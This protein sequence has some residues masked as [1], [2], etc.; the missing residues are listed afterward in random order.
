MPERTD[1]AGKAVGEA[2]RELSFTGTI[3]ASLIG[4]ALL[5]ALIVLLSFWAFRQ[6][7]ESVAARLH[8]YTLISKADALLSDI[9]NAE[10]GQ[11]GYS[12][13]G[14]EAFLKPYLAVRETIVRDLEELR[15]LTSVSAAQQRLDMV[16]PLVA[17]KL[18]ELSTVIESRRDRKM[19]SRLAAAGGSSQ[20]L[21]LMESIGAGMNN[22]IRIEEAVLEQNDQELRSDM[23]RLFASIVFAS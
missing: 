12:L 6:I 20:G 16:I 21:R 4:A 23:G 13:T 17:A 18:V 19:T 3:V 22:Y 7:E 10:T 5:A 1:A 9:T 11:R 15:R 8:T 14:D 2:P